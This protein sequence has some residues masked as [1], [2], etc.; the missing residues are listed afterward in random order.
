MGEEKPA[1]WILGWTSKGH[2]TAS[3]TA[4]LGP[5]PDSSMLKE[6]IVFAAGLGG[7]TGVGA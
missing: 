6:D 2:A 1:L 7:G 4:V 3:A 5:W